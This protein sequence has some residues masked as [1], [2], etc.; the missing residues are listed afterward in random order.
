MGETAMI[1]PLKMSFPKS[2]YFRLIEH[3]SK[4]RPRPYHADL[5][6]VLFIS[7]SRVA[8]GLALVSIFF[9]PSVVRTG[10]ALLF[11]SLATI[12]S[13]AHLKVPSRFLTMIRNNRSFLVWEVRLA[14]ALTT[15]L[16]LQF[17][18]FVGYLTA[19]RVFFVWINLVLAILFLISTGWAYRFETHPAWK[20]SILP[21]YYVVSACLIG[22][23]LR[24]I[25]SPFPGLPM[26]YAV[27]LAA[28]IALLFLYRKH[29][30]KTSPGALQALTEGR[31]KR[32]FLSFVWSS[33][34]LPLILTGVLLF[35][36]HEPILHIL[37]A[38]SCF[39]GIVI[40]RV[41][42]FQVERPV[43]FLSFV[44]NRTGTD[45]HWVRG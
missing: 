44:E 24:A 7:L 16:G 34:L 32:V 28:E 15:F 36:G 12:A 2:A 26:A 4:M 20:S 22:L 18:S 33:V 40:E 25:Y 31:E 30:M 6:L 27:L 37:M 29:L 38:A 1:T 17:L 10:V 11:M 35:R 45:R 9:A 3:Q 21:F 39:L 23:M 19:F 43:F 41:L 8:A 5:P 14:G 42:F 13:I